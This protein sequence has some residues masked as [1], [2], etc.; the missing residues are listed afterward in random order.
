M[1][2][3]SVEHGEA[4]TAL[5]LTDLVGR[6]GLAQVVQQ[7]SENGNT[8]SRVVE[9]SPYDPFLEDDVA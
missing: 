4:L 1:E 9:I 7:R 8:Y 6:E 3:C 5:D 2:P